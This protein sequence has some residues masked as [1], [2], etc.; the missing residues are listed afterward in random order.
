ML[1]SMI[2]FFFLY[3]YIYLEKVILSLQICLFCKVYME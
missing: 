3:I 2:F 1:P